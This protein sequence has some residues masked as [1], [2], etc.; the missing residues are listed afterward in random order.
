MNNGF[1]EVFVYKIRDSKV[2][3]VSKIIPFHFFFAGAGGGGGG[4]D[5]S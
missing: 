5:G 3:M 2:P 4:E 1:T